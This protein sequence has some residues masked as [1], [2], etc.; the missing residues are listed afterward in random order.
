MSSE[1]EEGARKEAARWY[2]ELQDAEAD[3][4]LWQRFLVWERD[5]VNA[6]AFRQI[7][8][9]LST[10]DRTRYAAPATQ[11]RPDRPHTRW[12]VLAAFAATVLLAA[13]GAITILGNNTS[14][15]HTDIYAT[16][17]GEQETV[18]LPDGSTAL[19]NTASRIEVTYSKGARHIHLTEGQALFEVVKGEA[20]FTV[21]AGGWDTTA[22]G[23]TFE[24]Y[25]P[26]EGVRVT[27]IEGSVSVTNDGAGEILAPG[28][29]LT[30]TGET[31]TKSRIDPTRALSWKSGMI[32]FTDV[33]LAEAAVEMNRYS[34]IK[35]RVDAQLADE[36]LSGVF[37]AGDQEGF[38]AALEAF[39]PVR[40]MRVDK[41]IRLIAPGDSAPPSGGSDL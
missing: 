13:L 39:L 38:A 21:E 3:P 25:L 31:L 36:R 6:A 10:L 26:P 34:D 28:D 8:A 9:A 20:P 32:T 4:A 23:T 16:R 29:Q 27:L 19:L 17:I 30:V 5:P 7:E 22:L 15:A 24:V 33:T 14:Q 2:A 1:P 40:S 35:L 18:T 12:P 41:T 11:P 37:R